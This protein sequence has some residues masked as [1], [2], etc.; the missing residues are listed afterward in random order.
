MAL[1]R[2]E[3]DK[4]EITT[5]RGERTCGMAEE[6]EERGERGEKRNGG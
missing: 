5:R 4:V 2:M 3:Q 1:A 6:G